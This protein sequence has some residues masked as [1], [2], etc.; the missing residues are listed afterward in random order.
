[1]SSVASAINSKEFMISCNATGSQF[2]FYAFNHVFLA[3]AYKDIALLYVHSCAIKPAALI[4]STDITLLSEL[5]S[6]KGPP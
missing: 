6:L 4:Y 2:L 5:L 1:M 3:G